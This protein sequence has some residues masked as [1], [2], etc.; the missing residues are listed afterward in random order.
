MTSAAS[1]TRR[2]AKG[3]AWMVLMRLSVRATGFVSILVLAR[4]LTPG[5]FGLVAMAS[6]M[7]GLLECLSEFS[8]D[9]ALIRDRT[10]DRSHYDTTWTLAIIRGLGIASVLAAGA[11]WAAAFYQDPRLEAVLYIVAFA[12]AISGFENV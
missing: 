1:V 3:A 2:M 10:A 8:F 11:S 6:S 7:L 12:S 4:L 5:D 9:M